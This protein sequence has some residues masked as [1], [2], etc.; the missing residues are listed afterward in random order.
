MESTDYIGTGASEQTDS[1]PLYQSAATTV[2]QA[3]PTA[4]PFNAAIFEHTIRNLIRQI[5][6]LQIP[7]SVVMTEMIVEEVERSSG[8]NF[9][10]L[11]ID[12]GNKLVKMETLAVTNLQK[13][14]TLPAC[15]FPPELMA[16]CAFGKD[17]EDIVALMDMMIE[18][19]YAK[20]D[21]DDYAI[22]FWAVV[23]CCKP[24]LWKGDGANQYATMCKQLWNADL[25]ANTITR[26][27][28][29]NGNDYQKWKKTTATCSVRHNIA[30]EFSSRL[31]SLLNITVK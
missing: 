25:K 5:D 15:R 19:Q 6:T 7:H 9:T 3:L 14:I 4:R 2:P 26:F 1:T 23:N 13:P 17:T 10:N 16:N 30:A 31:R 28:N 18:E 21:I 24:K 12:L 20:G 29:R 8:E 11:K 27:I 22:A